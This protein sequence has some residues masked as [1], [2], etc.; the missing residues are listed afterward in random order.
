MNNSIQIEKLSVP[1]HLDSAEAADFL[2]AVEIHRQAELRRWGNDDLAYTPEEI[3]ASEQDRYERHIHLL[4]KKADQVVGHCHLIL[5][6]E[7]NQHLLWYS[8]A[9]GT[10]REGEGIGSA[11]LAATEQ[12]AA[13][14]GRTTLTFETSHPVASLAAERLKPISGVGE[15]PADSREVRFAQR[16]GYLLEQVERF[17]RCELPIDPQ[18]LVEQQGIA[19]RVAG[20]DYRVLYW[21][22][23]CPEEWLEDY[24]YLQSRMSTDAP[25]AGLAIEEEPWDGA[26]VRQS[27]ELAL[28][29]GR[30]TLVAAAQHLPSGKLAGFTVITGLAHRQDMVFQDNTLVLREH[31]GHKLGLLV[32]VAN[33][34]SLAEQ[35][36]QVRRIYTW[37]AAENEYMLAVNIALG[38]EPAGYTG[39][40]QK[41]IG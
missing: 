26:R 23:H 6:V 14:E 7:D 30:T 3:L 18:L 39:E 29:L 22:N 20:A 4:A 9:V 31:R 15:L 35:M 17:S 28:A 5:P 2:A 34:R 10:Q 11:L 32:K 13:D 41:V 12:L 19:E 38:F 24:A 37:N 33:L 1:R 36:P 8:L 40:W 21:R 25:R 16:A 27:E